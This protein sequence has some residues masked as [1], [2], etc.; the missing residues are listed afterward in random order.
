MPG[1]RIFVG[2]DIEGNQAI[3]TIKNTAGYEMDF[4][5]EEILQRFTRGDQA[6]SKEG[7]GL[8]LSIAESFTKVCGGDFEVKLDGDQFNVI[9]SFHI[10][11]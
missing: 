3:A 8:G 4:T 7:S 5:A 11:Q 9:I 1:T 6:R 10:E 2:L